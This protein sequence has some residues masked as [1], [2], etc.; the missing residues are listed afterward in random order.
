MRRLPL[1]ALVVPPLLLLIARELAL[2]D[3]TSEMAW[4]LFH[5]LKDVAKPAWL[6][7]LLPRPA[8][9]LYDDP[10]AQ[11]LALFAVLLATAYATAAL[12][13]ARPRF[14]GALLAISALLL[15]AIPTAAVIALG[16]ATGRP[17]GHDG[18]VVQLPLA[19]ERVVAGLSP[20]GAHYSDGVLGEQARDSVFWKPLGGN[21]ITQH[22][23]Y[24]PGMHLVMAPFY[25][26][27]RAAWGSF[28][29]RC[30]T[31]LG[32][33]VAALLA[34]RLFPDAERRLSAA[35][36]VLLH[37]FVFWP[38][39]FGTNDVLS[40]VPLLLAAG[41]ARAGR[42][43]TAAILIGL[44]ASIKQLT[45]PFAPFLLVYAAGIS[46][47]TELRTRD[48]ARRLARLALV[49]VATFLVVV[50]PIALRDWD[51]FF[52][53]IV[54][55]QTGS[56][57][58]DQYPLGGTPGFGFAN[59]LIYTGSVTSLTDFYPFH[60]FFLLFVPAGL[61]LL[62][63]Q[64]RTRDL[65]GPLVAGAAALLVS[66]YF[67]RIPNPNYVTLA[68]LFLPLALLLRPRLGLDTALVPL[69]LIALALEAAQGLILRTTWDA[70]LGLGL[71]D[72]LQPDP[73]GPRWRDPL[74]TGWGGALAGLAILYLFGA[75]AGLGRRGRVALLA[76][77]AVVSLGLPFLTIAE[78]GRAA[79]V[80]RAQDRFL[81]EA[82][83][84]MQ[85][86][87]PGEWG[88]RPGVER[89]PVLEAWPASWRKDPPR[90]LPR[91]LT[92]P[93][94]FTVGRLSRA[95]GGVDPRAPMLALVLGVAAVLLWGSATS[96]RLAIGGALLLSPPLV[97][98][99]LFG[100]AA[101][102]QAALLT[103][104]L[105]VVR[106]RALVAGAAAATWPP[107]FVASL[108]LVAWPQWLA[109]GF[110]VA[111][112]PLVLGYWGEYWR[113]L[114]TAPAL[115][116]SL[117]LTNLAFY[118]PD[119]AE[120]LRPWL[121]PLG[122]LLLGVLAVGLW[123]S[124]TF[125]GA[126]LASAA[127]LSTATLLIGPPATGHAVAVPILLFLLAGGEGEE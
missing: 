104:A 76:A 118:R 121:W 100:S 114:S 67:S 69:A 88:R 127:A 11:L 113:V 45:W 19:L 9:V 23:W 116:P 15:V 38:Q 25:R 98:G 26:L 62:R 97:V 33:V 80:A 70:A 12:L 82:V 31:L 92:S 13:G 55:Y 24:L 18:G 40:A 42:A 22:H 63:Y 81:A 28:D 83:E 124:G 65:A 43:T 93:G 120:A 21:P 6:A 35:G 87:G 37:P 53:D 106:G 39:V 14:R 61:L 91:E 10:V 78:G 85:A 60:R 16:F 52:A 4:P 89:T 30:V 86:P 75:L 95:L 64:F 34:G 99:G 73:A 112:A 72:F 119:L 77:A 48:G 5:E 32:Y 102:L 107:L 7:V 56:P 74:S 57:G 111:G 115:A 101:P 41:C 59:L 109:L 1:D 117:G 51:A 50:L 44:A 123:W 71:P 3:P 20:Y 125:R 110:F 103:G 68:A 49:S 27:S 54:R 8:A 126:P 94:A 66:L 79:G 58:S 47:L 108:P 122:Q 2:F 36:L 90:E 46:S 84:A 96:A 105:L 17:Y 29:P